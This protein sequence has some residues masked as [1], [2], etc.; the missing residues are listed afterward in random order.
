M[1]RSLFAKKI[2]L[3]L[4][5]AG[6]G[7]L[8]SWNEFPLGLG[9]FWGIAIAVG[10]LS[11]PL[12]TERSLQP[13]LPRWLGLAFVIFFAAFVAYSGHWNRISVVAIAT[14]AFFYRGAFIRS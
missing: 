7:P 13:G 4:V 8:I 2:L 9:I 10:I 3:A 11:A 12:S 1:A 5:A 6:I 14:L